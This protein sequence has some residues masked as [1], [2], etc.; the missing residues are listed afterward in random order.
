M[1][2]IQIHGLQQGLLHLRIQVSRTGPWAQRHAKRVWYR[3]A[4]ITAAISFL[5]HGTTARSLSLRR[6][7]TTRKGSRIIYT[8]Q[9]GIPR[10]HGT[11]T[12]TNNVTYTTTFTSITTQTNNWT[13]DPSFTTPEPTCTISYDDCSSMYSSYRSSLGLPWTASLPIVTPAP[14]N[15]PRCAD[16]VGGYLSSHYTYASGDGCWNG[17]QSAP[18]E[19]IGTSVRLFYWYTADSLTIASQSALGN[20]SRNSTSP[21]TTTLGDVTFTCAYNLVVVDRTIADHFLSLHAA[22]TVYISIETVSI[23]T[24]IWDNDICSSYA[25]GGQAIDE[26]VPVT[27]VLL[28]LHPNELSSVVKRPPGGW[29]PASVAH[30]IAFGESDYYSLFIDLKDQSAYSFAAV[31]YNAIASPPP[32]AY[33]LGLNMP[34]GCNEEG[35]HP[36]CSTIFDGAY[37]PGLKVP[38]QLLSMMTGFE[39]CIQALHGLYDPRK[40]T[41]PRDR[42]TPLTF[43]S[44]RYQL[45]ELSGWCQHHCRY[46]ADDA[47]HGCESLLN[48][49]RPYSSTDK[50]EGGNECHG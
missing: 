33:Y 32:I 14:S 49:S 31:D 38:K 10:A 30:D 18:C 29:D 44:T 35:P 36:E 7:V 40:Y 47:H 34:P 15:S 13:V 24:F 9:D 1:P 25:L 23:E 6:P 42:A 21:V 4:K 11:L 50:F 39:Q 12:V 20:V 46:T 19:I 43:H 27:T 16:A 3:G 2:Q 48:T 22:P 8:T 45:S 41:T 17:F 37:R 5:T 26:M 28:S